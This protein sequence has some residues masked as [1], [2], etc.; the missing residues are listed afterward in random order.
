MHRT[1][2]GSAV[3]TIVGGFVVLGAQ[4][5]P[6][7]P[8]NFATTLAVTTQELTEL[9]EWDGRIN[10]LERSG[11]LALRTV[12]ADTLLTG[13]A[14]ERYDQY[15]GGVRVFGGDIARQTGTGVTESVFGI[16]YDRIDIPTTPTLSEEDARDR[17]A[18]LS[19]TEFPHERPVELVILPKDEGGYALTWRSH[20][21]ANDDWLN[22]FIDANNGNLVL[23]YSDLRT[24]M[25]VGTGTGVLGDNQYNSPLWAIY[26]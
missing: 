19:V 14:H 22:T 5:P 9:R 25:S 7:A 26:G 15:V 24:Q 1:V 13:R 17:F 12:R 8:Q 2:L 4:T 21:W 11:G 20:V 16:V 3:A 10:A 6:P 23:S 18:V